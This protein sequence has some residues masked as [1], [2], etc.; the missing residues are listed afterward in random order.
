M[1]L[2]YKYETMAQ[3][4]I[5]THTK[6]WKAKTKKKKEVLHK[7]NCV[8]QNVNTVFM[9][10]FH[11]NETEFSRSYWSIKNNEK[12]NQFTF[13]RIVIPLQSNIR[14]QEEKTY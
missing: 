12:K 9:I 1:F 8:L 13:K 3:M 7:K 5:M 2:Y 4:K 6:T 11:L 10:V 14:F